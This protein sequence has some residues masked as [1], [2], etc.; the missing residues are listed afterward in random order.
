[1]FCKS[2]GCQSVERITAKSHNGGLLTM[3]LIGGMT[4]AIP[5][6]GCSGPLVG[7]TIV[8][9]KTALENQVLGTYQELNQE[10]LL[11]AS[12]RYI[13]PSGKLVPQPPIPPSKEAAIRAMQRS[14]FNRDDIDRLKAEGILGENLEGEL[15]ILHPENI[16]ADR[17]A[18]VKNLVE[19]EN[20]D[21]AMLMQRVLATNET[22]T[23]QDLPKIR[24]TF[25][26]LN[27]DR[28]RSGDWIQRED[29]QWVRKP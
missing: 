12:V 17:H 16:P 23:P 18:F 9:E 6:V 11:V 22:F 21:R 15:T 14:A 25:A 8:D 7:V 19:E 2:S 3:V 27:R 1:M 29:G 26:A 4:W 20:A 28:A 13:D 10:V 24:R 5:L